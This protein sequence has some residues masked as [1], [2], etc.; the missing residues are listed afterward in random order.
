MD[1]D[2]KNQYEAYW[3]AALA[4][5]AVVAE[6]KA[7]KEETSH[8]NMTLHELDNPQQDPLRRTER[9]ELNRDP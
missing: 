2:W 8:M 9:S 4:R 5:L 6:E 1:C 7:W 3:D